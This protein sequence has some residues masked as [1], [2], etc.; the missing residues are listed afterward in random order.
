G[1][2]YERSRRG[3]VSRQNRRDRRL[4]RD[5][6]AGGPSL[7]AR[8]DG[9]DP[10]R[11]RTGRGFGQQGARRNPEPARSAAR[12]HLPPAL[13]D[14]GL[15]MPRAAGARTASA[16]GDARGQLLAGVVGFRLRGVTA[17]WRAAYEIQTA[18]GDEQGRSRTPASIGGR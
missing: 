16:R 1:R 9:G 15:P 6:R 3:D 18:E 5:L 13:P 4:A 17:T 14:R 2:A 8:A 11:V 12:L 10:G 7:H